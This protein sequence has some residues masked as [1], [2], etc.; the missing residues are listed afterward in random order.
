MTNTSHTT[1]EETQRYHGERVE[2]R[3]RERADAAF[4]QS[5]NEFFADHRVS[6]DETPEEFFARINK[7]DKQ[8]TI[9]LHAGDVFFTALLLDIVA[10]ATA[11]EPETQDRIDPIDEA[12]VPPFFKFWEKLNK[13][14][15][16]AGKPEAGYKTAKTAFEGGETPAGA[17]TFVGKEWEGIRA[18][19]GPTSC[20]EA[21][22]FGEFREVSDAG[23]VWRV[24]ANKH[25][26]SIAYVSAEGAL[27]SAKLAKV[28]A[29]GNNG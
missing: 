16:A 17:L 20:G 7:A 6:L 15:R 4:F 1:P 5:P 24:V 13:G 23:T 22:Y 18:V 3:Q 9:S 29:E 28:H 21:S 19:P 27:R 11:E 25:G 12:N 10:H 8:A 26:L 2:A 14:L